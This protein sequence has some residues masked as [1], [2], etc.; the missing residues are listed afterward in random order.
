[1]EVFD[2]LGFLVVVL[3]GGLAGL[4]LLVAV[5]ELLVQVGCLVQLVGV[6]VAGVRVVGL[7]ILLRMVVRVEVLID[8]VVGP[9]VAVVGGEMS[10]L[11]GYFFLC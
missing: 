9:A 10:C 1:M 4:A 8:F 5:L 11:A 7:D 3:A 6:M 2:G